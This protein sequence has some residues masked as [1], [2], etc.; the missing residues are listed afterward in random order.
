M[1][2][3]YIMLEWKPLL[4]FD[5]QNLAKIL[6][7]PAPKVDFNMGDIGMLSTDILLAMVTLDMLIKL[8]IIPESGVYSLHKSSSSRDSQPEGSR[9]LKK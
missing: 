5:F 6:R 4:L 7:N 3:C 8:G 1:K 9:Q 2:T